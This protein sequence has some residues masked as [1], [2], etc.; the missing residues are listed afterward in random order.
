MYVE[1]YLWGIDRSEPEGSPYRYYNH[2]ITNAISEISK[3]RAE[4]I[5]GKEIDENWFFEQSLNN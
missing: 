2:E 3:E 1:D 5:I 4:R